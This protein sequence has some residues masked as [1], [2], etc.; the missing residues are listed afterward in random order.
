MYVSSLIFIRI[1]SIVT[2]KKTTRSF[3]NRLSV[4]KVLINI[5]D[6]AQRLSLVIACFNFARLK[7]SII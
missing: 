7:N 5:S 1:F 2:T 4:I 3:G 6:K